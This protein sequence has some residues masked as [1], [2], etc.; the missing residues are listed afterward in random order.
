M[1]EPTTLMMGAG[2][3]ISAASAAAQYSAQSSMASAQKAQ[4]GAETANALANL[5]NQYAQAQQSA[6]G[7]NAAAY[8][9]QE[10]DMRATRAAEATS[11]TS[12]GEN[13]VSG[14]SMAR[15]ANEYN[16]NSA[17]YMADVE[18]NQNMT[19]EELMTQMQGFQSQA[20]SIIN[21]EPVPNYPSPLGLGLEIGGD[22]L[23][24]YGTY[25]QMPQTHLNARLTPSV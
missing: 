1:C 25:R 5:R 2:L 9:K 3:A 20:Q 21:R 11:L 6:V 8:Q 14:N 4:N 19:D 18:M 22:A 13:G 7:Q 10:Q 24:A 15:L 17:E 12:A 16:G 23:N